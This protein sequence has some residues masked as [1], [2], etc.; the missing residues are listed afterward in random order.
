MIVEDRIG[1][2]RLVRFAVVGLFGEFDHEI[3]LSSSSRV[4]ALIAPNGMGK[5]ACLR[6][7][8]ALFQRKWSVF[9]ATEFE[10]VTYE[11]SDGSV[12]EA[13]RSEQLEAFDES[14]QSVMFHIFSGGQTENWSPRHTES[15][16]QRMTMRL[17]RYLPY[18]TQSGPNRWVHDFTRQVYNLQELIENY[19]DQIPDAALAGVTVSVSPL[20]A[21]IIDAIDCHL[22][23]TQRLLILADEDARRPGVSSKLT[24]SKKAQTLKEIIA[25]ELTSYA[26]LS[27]SLDRSF[28]KRVIEMGSIPPSEDLKGSLDELDAL[29]R[30]LM[31]AGILDTEHEDTLLPPG[32]VNSAIA[33]VLSVYVRDTRRKL[34]S[35][36]TI[37]ERLTLF[38][39]LIDN[40]FKPKSISVDKRTG[41]SVKRGEDVTVPLEKLSSGE[42]HQLVLF[43]ELLFE[44]KSNALILIDEPEL[45]LHVAWQKKFIADL[46]RI[47]SLNEFDVLLATHSPQLIGRWTDIVVELG[48]VDAA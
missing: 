22:I 46:Q 1:D 11:F 40:R 13:R 9:W 26:T 47:I 8:N 5:T 25:R 2:L 32:Q 14:P 41:F 16:P 27:Q 44:L 17:D 15:S 43:F 30:K 24:I 10:R 34:E 31:D 35:L 18:I 45:S 7:I 21:K 48:D 39:E 37:L 36:S 19:G 28:P 23:E 42:Q 33:A 6:L 38:I 3:P 4:T 20:F 29:R 12:V